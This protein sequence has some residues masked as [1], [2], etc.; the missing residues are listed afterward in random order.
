MNELY[1]DLGKSVLMASPLIIGIVIKIWMDYNVSQ[2]LKDWGIVAFTIG[3]LTTFMII[4]L[5][6]GKPFERVNLD[7]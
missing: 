6:F 3:L 5:V 4:V 2:E 7:D 1:K